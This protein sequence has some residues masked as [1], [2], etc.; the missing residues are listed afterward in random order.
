MA[1]LGASISGPWGIFEGSPWWHAGCN[2]ALAVAGWLMWHTSERRVLKMTDS[3]PAGGAVWQIPCCGLV[4]S[5]LAGFFAAPHSAFVA[6][7]ASIALAGVAALR[8]SRG[9]LERFALV[10]I[11]IG[12]AA[13]IAV[14]ALRAAVP[15]PSVLLPAVSAA[16][17]IVAT[18]LGVTLNRRTVWHGPVETFRR[19]ENAA[20]VSRET[21]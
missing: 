5:A 17:A 9:N 2:L 10:F 21:R 1:L 20:R 3:W 7:P 12:N 18:A 19:R 16:V 6:V 15:D 13:E 8:T 11:V 14:I 4:V